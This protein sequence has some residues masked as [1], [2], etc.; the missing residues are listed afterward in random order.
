MSTNSF[1]LR[2]PRRVTAY[3]LLFGLTAVIWLSAGAFYVASSV[4]QSRSESACLRWL[5]RA[6]ARLSLNYLRNG[7]AD[8]Q[9]LIQELHTQ[10]GAVYCAVL[11]R[12]GVYLAHSSAELVGQ[13]AAEN[14]GDT[15]Q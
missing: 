8:L 3:F 1:Q 5:G 13:P 12:T 6:S 14:K 11:S 9:P 2:L 7:E 10:S 4:S 15:D